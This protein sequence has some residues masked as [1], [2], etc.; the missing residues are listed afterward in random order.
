VRGLALVVIAGCGRIHF[1]PLGDAAL[2]AAGPPSG[3]ITIAG[4]AMP[5]N[6]DGP[7]LQARFHNPVNL[8]FG[9]GGLLYVMDYDNTSIRAI[10]PDFT[11]STI[12]IVNSEPFGVVGSD[13]DLYI[14]DDLDPTG[15]KSSPLLHVDVGTGTLTQ[16]AIGFGEARGLGL[17][18]DGTI[19][20]SDVFDHVI[21]RLDPATRNVTVLAG[22]L[23]TA[24]WQDGVGTSARFRNPYDLVVLPDQT[25]VVADQGNERLRQVALDGTVT[26]IAGDGTA[27]SIDGIGLAASFYDPQSLALDAAGNFYIGDSSS[28]VIRRMSPD[29]RVVT[30]AGMKGVTGHRDAAD[31]LAAQF[32]NLEGMTLRGRYLYVADGNADVSTVPSHFIRRIDLASLVP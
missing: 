23:G 5:G 19:V 28:F 7:G 13:S 18:A 3:V 12:A 4:S 30:V 25:I 2:D 31:P 32:Y 22:T 29:G 24:G 27:S 20:F 1:E 8:D 15:T 26:T 21:R 17:L 10:A 14:E 16:L 9:P 6:A 11:V